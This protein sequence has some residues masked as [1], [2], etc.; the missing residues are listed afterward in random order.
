MC[1]WGPDTVTSRRLAKNQFVEKSP[2]FIRMVQIASRPNQLLNENA[3]M[4]M[5]I[6]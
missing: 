1:I 6:E 3:A 5:Q 4:Q 2:A